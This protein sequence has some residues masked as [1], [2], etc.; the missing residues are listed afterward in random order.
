MMKKEVEHRS[1]SDC[2]SQKDYWADIFFFFFK[3]GLIMSMDIL[4]KIFSEGA[5]KDF[6]HSDWDGRQKGLIQARYV[7]IGKV[8]IR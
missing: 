8:V 1:T 4:L 2:L 7:I 6:S 5:W 3:H